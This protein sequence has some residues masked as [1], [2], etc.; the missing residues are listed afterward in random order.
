MLVSLCSKE[1]LVTEFPHILTNTIQGDKSS[2]SSLHCIQSEKW[3][4]EPYKQTNIDQRS[5]TDLLREE[6]KIFIQQLLQQLQRE[7]NEYEEEIKAILEKWRTDNTSIS[8]YAGLP[9]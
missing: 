9:H 6:L 7:Q 8:F 4:F 1:S 3:F 5:N 2:A